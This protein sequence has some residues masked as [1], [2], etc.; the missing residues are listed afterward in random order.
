MNAAV[1]AATR[2]TIRHSRRFENPISASSSI[3]R[4]QPWQRWLSSSSPSSSLYNDSNNLPSKMIDFS[5]SAKIE[6]EESQ[7]A[8]VQLRPGETLRAESGAM[9]F[10]THGV[11]MNT[12][13]QGASA[14]FSR[15]MTGQN[16][17][18][19]D[20]TYNGEKGQGTV[21]LGTDFPSKIL[22][23]SLED[24]PGSTLICQ[25][26][27]Y[28]A[29]NP[30][31][32]I[33]MEATKSLS[34]GFFGGQGFILQRLS[35]A[36][37]VLVKA[38][39]TLVEKD[40]EEGET[41]RVTSGS[42]VAF[43]GSVDYDI[44]MMPGVKNAM[45]GG[46]GLFVTKLTG[47]GKVWLQGMPADR[48]IAEIARRVPSGGPGIGIPIGMGGGGGA[49][50][51]AEGAAEG[52]EGAADVPES[53]EE[54]VAATDQAID[55]DR[56]TTVASSGMAGD[57]DA[58]SPSALYGDAAPQ[59]DASSSAASPAD[60][61]FASSADDSMSKETTFS[62]D[63]TAFT[64]ETNFSD[65]T[66]FSDTEFQPDQEESSFWGSDDQTKTDVFDSGSG[67]GGGDEEGGS[68]IIS[69]LWDIFMGGDDD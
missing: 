15:L 56:Q 9:L 42:I 48:M 24:Y 58:D 10:M 52:G 2:S 6:G 57:V 22:R 61:P 55:A 66:S 38:G 32:D 5:I 46:E 40:L 14:A 64:D 43:T 17:F 45:F 29:S 68:S 23:L 51:G 39:G 62:D 34:A 69:T 41:L 35:G 63:N 13:L 28:M 30:S 47:P 27:A 37:D 16:V 59:D 31:V 3:R 33:S 54:M 7:V 26:G 20:F 44:Q 18:L 19:T 4:Q 12:D 21:G 49:G 11:E 36:G 60:D 53:G 8:M 25:R 1:R 67:D 65:E 50:E